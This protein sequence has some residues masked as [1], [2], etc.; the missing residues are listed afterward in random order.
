MQIIDEFDDKLSLY[1]EGDLSMTIRVVIKDQQKIMILPIP[2]THLNYNTYRADRAPAMN[3]DLY[4]G[5]IFL[6]YVLNL[7]LI[8]Y[9]SNSSHASKICIC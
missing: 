8:C 1:M 2:G 6:I 5:F 7:F 3:S 4:V 9:V